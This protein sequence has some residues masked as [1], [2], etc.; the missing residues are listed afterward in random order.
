[1]PAPRRYYDYSDIMSILSVSR[2]KAWQYLRM[3]ERWGL[4]F[5][6]GKVLRVRMDF[7]DAYLD[8]PQ[9]YAAKAE[10]QLRATARRRMA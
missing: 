8:N 6:E 2:T 1:M 4:A 10:A 7:F 5:R 9:E 3:F